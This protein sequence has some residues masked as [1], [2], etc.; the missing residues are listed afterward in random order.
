[1]FGLQFLIYNGSDQI[2]WNEA[3]DLLRLLNYMAL[4]IVEGKCFVLKCMI[5]IELFWMNGNHIV[6]NNLAMS[7]ESTVQKVSATTSGYLS[8]FNIS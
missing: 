1:M 4:K 5:L 6:H 7:S 2:I 3:L 8:S